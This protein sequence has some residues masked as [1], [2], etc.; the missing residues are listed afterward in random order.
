M[1]ILYE[2]SAEA[3]QAIMGPNGSKI[4]TVAVRPRLDNQI[5]S[6]QDLRTRLIL[7]AIGKSITLWPAEV[8]SRGDGRRLP[9]AESGNPLDP[10]SR[11]ALNPSISIQFGEYFRG[12]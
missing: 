1:R 2:T 8:H 9:F 12:S 7:L 5:L 6:R 11:L 3:G 10:I 4:H